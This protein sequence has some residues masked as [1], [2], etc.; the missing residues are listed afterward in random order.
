MN[1]RSDEEV[2]AQDVEPPAGS[3]L[4]DAS[5]VDPEQ[6]NDVAQVVDGFTEFLAAG[7]SPAPPG[8]HRR[9][10]ETTAN[11]SGRAQHSTSLS[12]AE[13]NGPS[14][15]A[16]FS[17]ILQKVSSSFESTLEH[18]KR[19]IGRHEMLSHAQENISGLAGS[20]HNATTAHNQVSQTSAQSSLESHSHPVEKTTSLRSLRLNSSPASRVLYSFINPRTRDL[21]V[22]TERAI[23]A[24]DCIRER[25]LLEASLHVS[26]AT[27]SPS[28]NASHDDGTEAVSQPENGE[29]RS[30]RI[31]VAAIPKPWKGTCAEYLPATE[32]VIVGNTDG[33][34]RIFSVQSGRMGLFVREST[35]AA[36][37]PSDFSS[38]PCAMT[39]LPVRP[40]RLLVGFHDGTLRIVETEDLQVLN[41]FNAPEISSPPIGTG[42]PGSP[43]RCMD[44]ITPPEDDPLSEPE[45]RV[46]IGFADGAVYTRLV[47]SGDS[48]VEF[49]AHSGDVGGVACLFGGILC[50]TIGT[51]ED[52]S[53][54]VSENGN[55]RCL[56]R[57]ML[58]YNP[59]CLSGVCGSKQLHQMRSRV[60]CPSECTILV[61]GAEGEVEVF[62]VNVL[63]EIKVE[64]Q[65]ERR[66]SE[67]GR[68]RQREVKYLFYDAVDRL[69]L[70][71]SAGG[72][73]RRWRLTPGDASLIG[74]VEAEANE[75]AKIH[76]GNV[77]ELLYADVQHNI[78]SRLCSGESVIAAQRILATVLEDDV[79]VDESGK[80]ALVEE[81]QRHQAEMQE[82]ATNADKEY[83][84]ARRRIQGRFRFALS[85][86]RSPANPM[87]TDS[88]GDSNRRWT[89]VSCELVRA[90]RC[91]AAHELYLA[92]KRHVDQISRVRSSAVDRLRTALLNS[93][94]TATGSLDTVQPL[95][96]AAYALKS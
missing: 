46:H 41:Q 70:A 20:I 17:G 13:N 39:L 90:A 37:S 94:R 84:R 61:G 35:S 71:I 91:T 95:R 12:N 92:Q 3:A 24:F 19:E 44:S 45:V 29:R 78:E 50:A 31:P 16:F 77:T 54:C 48:R 65:L 75:G 38:Y 4:R 30:P 93:L 26:R 10:A 76:E 47:S 7:D 15:G 88:L 52:P 51:D 87:D 74:F 69:I 60:C 56:I 72:E 27:G 63:S 68:G 43:V 14:P 83:S 58:P 5:A 85:D 64:L 57:R 67:R 55:G 73:I 82:A 11:L 18:A 49:I 32:E 53:I 1:A 80:D 42:L 22:V 8:T 66:I 59:T 40:S 33:F 28:S 9:S 21:I 23:E 34:L 36:S 62:R 6:Q 25:K 2:L 81:F 89:K 96:S 79:G 86:K